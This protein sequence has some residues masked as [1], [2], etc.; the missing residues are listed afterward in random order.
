MSQVR[1]VTI[2]S[3]KYKIEYAS[4]PTLHGHECYGMVDHGKATIELNDSNSTERD[5]QTLL[6]EIVHVIDEQRGLSLSEEQVDKLAY[7]ILDLIRTNDAFI[8]LI[9]GE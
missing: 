9:K 8:K 7:G 3:V 1:A 5:I 6:H 4:R 2:G